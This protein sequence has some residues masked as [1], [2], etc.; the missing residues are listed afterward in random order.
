MTP[1][2]AALAAA[3]ARLPSSES[4]L[5]LGH[6][7]RRPPVWLLANDDALLGED[8][9]L[10]FASLVARRAGGEPIAYLVGSREFFGREFAVSPAVLIPRPETELLVELAVAK[11]APAVRRGSWIWAPAAAASR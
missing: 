2:A 4:R 3:Q 6:V 8:A 5:L 11:S 10:A 1:V 9:L 7:L